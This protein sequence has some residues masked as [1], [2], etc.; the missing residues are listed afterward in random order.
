M[1]S[2][3]ESIYASQSEIPTMTKTTRKVRDFRSE[4]D[5]RRSREH[6]AAKQNREKTAA[7]MEEAERIAQDKQEVDEQQQ[8][9]EEQRRPDAP[10]AYEP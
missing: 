7:E 4:I 10:P 5:C 6:K 2:H 8:L 1:T 9:L 3:R